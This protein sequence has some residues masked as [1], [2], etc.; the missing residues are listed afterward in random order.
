MLDLR[1]EVHRNGFTL[2]VALVFGAG[3]TLL[4]G[5]NGAGKTTLLR[6]IL[7]AVPVRRGAIRL[8]GRSL[9]DSDSRVDLPTEDRRVGWVP[10]EYALFPHLTVH[11]NV[12]FGVR[13]DVEGRRRHVEGLLSQLGLDPLTAR[14]PSQ[15]SGG[16]R[17][18]VAIARALAAEPDALLLDEPVAALDVQMRDAIRSF[19]AATLRSLAIPSIVVTHDARDAAALDGPLV[20]L[21][22]GRALGSGYYPGL[23]AAPPS[24]FARSFF[25]HATG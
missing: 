10:Q 5:P 1:I 2:D 21:E 19:L 17:Q 25:E 7:G 12:A 20:V 15:L 11:Q 13:G 22:A 8:G 6:A 23:Q 14:F 18:K 16:E 24:P 3:P 4:I 9:F